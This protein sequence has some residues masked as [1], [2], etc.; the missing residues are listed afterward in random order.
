MQKNHTTIL[1]NLAHRIGI[2]IQRGNAVSKGRFHGISDVD[3]LSY[4]RSLVTVSYVFL[5]CYLFL[6]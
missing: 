4:Y 1:L 5:K 3:Q 2:S 6:Y